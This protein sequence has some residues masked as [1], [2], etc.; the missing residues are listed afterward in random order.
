MSFANRNRDMDTIKE[1]NSKDLLTQ[2]EINELLEELIILREIESLANDLLCKPFNISLP[3]SGAG[4]GVFTRL[5]LLRES[6]RKYR[7]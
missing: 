3:S 4:A 5:R 6:V 7:I 2:N 1:L